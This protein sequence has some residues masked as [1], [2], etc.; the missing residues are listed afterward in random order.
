MNLNGICMTIHKS[1]KFGLEVEFK[2]FYLERIWWNSY[3]R[4]WVV[5]WHFEKRLK[6]HFYFDA[7][8]LYEMLDKK[9]SFY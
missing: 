6:I 2:M 8:T 9:W 7:G 1:D 4:N 3:Y 5:G